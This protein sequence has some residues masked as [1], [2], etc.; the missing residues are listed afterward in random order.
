MGLHHQHVKQRLRPWC[1]LAIATQEIKSDECVTARTLV[2]L[3]DLEQDGIDE[4]VLELSQVLPTLRKARDTTCLGLV[5]ALDELITR[6]QLIADG[7]MP[8]WARSPT[9]ENLRV[10]AKLRQLKDY[11]KALD[12]AQHQKM[13]SMEV[14]RM[15]TRESTQSIHAM[16]ES[17]NRL[18]H[19]LVL[20]EIKRVFHTVRSLQDSEP[21]TPSG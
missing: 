8:R 17:I 11:S 13:G 7:Q 18:H 2:I 4:Y 19:T 1:V 15:R 10:P 21:S 6:W 5:D 9:G 16:P 20:Q 12:L 3:G 14:Q